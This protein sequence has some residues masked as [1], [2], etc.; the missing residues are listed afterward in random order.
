MAPSPKE[1]LDIANA[2]M[3]LSQDSSARRLV[4]ARSAIAGP[5]TIVAPTTVV[6]PRVNA[7]LATSSTNLIVATPINSAVRPAIIASSQATKTGRDKHRT[8]TNRGEIFEWSDNPH[9]TKAAMVKGTNQDPMLI[10]RLKSTRQKWFEFKYPRRGAINWDDKKEVLNANNWRW[11]IIRRT[12]DKN[13]QNLIR[14]LRWTD[15]EKNE[16]KKQIKLRK[17]TNITE[18]E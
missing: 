10:V 8:V 4:E 6:R 11:Q 15:N 17:P 13:K 14:R 12:L 16:L 2:L 5:S 18:K 9:I 1:D 3:Q 7:T